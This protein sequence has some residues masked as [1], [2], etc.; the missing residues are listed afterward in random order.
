MSLVLFGLYK[1]PFVEIS[2][3]EDIG[4]VEDFEWLSVFI[5]YCT[6]FLYSY[7]GGRA[8]RFSKC[9]SCWMLVLAV[10]STHI[11]RIRGYNTNPDPPPTSCHN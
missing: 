9:D 3:N 10:R 5:F 6:D 8:G 1:K 11:N 2:C 7:F 4:P